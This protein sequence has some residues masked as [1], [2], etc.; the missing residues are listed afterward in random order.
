MKIND[1]SLQ[2]GVK[3]HYVKTQTF[4]Y[5]W[6]VLFVGAVSNFARLSVQEF[7]RAQNAPNIFIEG[8]NERA[9]DGKSGH[10]LVSPLYSEIVN[11][12]MASIDIPGLEWGCG[13]T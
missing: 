13:R 5:K 1:Y 3:D 4:N 8:T 6:F 11:N 2:F 7:S 12:R 9:Y 10:S